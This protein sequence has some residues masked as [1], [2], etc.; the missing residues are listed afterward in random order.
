MMPR[1]KSNKGNLSRIKKKLKKEARKKSKGFT[2]DQIDNIKKLSKQNKGKSFDKSGKVIE[3][4]S[5]VQGGSP[6][7]GKGKS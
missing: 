1:N 3:K 4:I 6:G 2:K 5:L 7:L